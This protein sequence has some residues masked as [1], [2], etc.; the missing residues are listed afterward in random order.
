MPRLNAFV[1]P[2]YPVLFSLAQ[3]EEDYGV[4]TGLAEIS[5]ALLVGG[6]PSF[7]ASHHVPDERVDEIVT[8]LEAGDVRVAVVGT[9]VEDEAPV[10]G[11]RRPAAFISLLCADG[12]RLSVARL[13]APDESAA[14]DRLARHVIRQIARGVQVP[15]LTA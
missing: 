7:L 14:P 8:S 9:W 13:M 4:P 11:T 12:R 1:T 5:L 15:D 3:G 6:L 2:E 10:P